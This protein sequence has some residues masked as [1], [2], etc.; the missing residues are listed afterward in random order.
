MG[1]FQNYFPYIYI[2]IY[3]V[4]YFCHADINITSPHKDLTNQHK[5]ILYDKWMHKNVLDIHI[6]FDKVNTENQYHLQVFQ[7]ENIS[8]NARI[9]MHT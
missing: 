6:F 1:R 4:A 7:S 8:V 5:H 2:Y 9:L 3:M